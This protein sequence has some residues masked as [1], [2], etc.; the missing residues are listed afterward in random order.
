MEVSRRCEHGLSECN[1]LSCRTIWRLE[2]ELHAKTRELDSLQKEVASHE[3]L[4]P[5][6]YI[7][8]ITELEDALGKSDL[9]V[10]SLRTQLK[11]REHAFTLIEAPI[12]GLLEMA[13]KVD[14]SGGDSGLWRH[15]VKT[16]QDAATSVRE[17]MAFMDAAR[18]KVAINRKCGREREDGSPC[19][20]P[21]PCP[22][23]FREQK[24]ADYLETRDGASLLVKAV[25]SLKSCSKCGKV[26]H[27]GKCEDAE[28]RKCGLPIHIAGGPSYLCERGAGHRE[29]CGRSEKQ[30][31]DCPHPN[32]T[33]F[34]GPCRACG[35]E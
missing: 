10:E 17:S 30:V 32:P 20:G 7:N 18:A 3:C 26:W 19:P 27:R 8:R 14:R 25:D 24:M 21:V 12:P 5:I 34:V 2:G 23:H 22:S 33:G 6:R 11:D 13:E 31:A 28:K 15:S 1:V 4:P 35:D 9:Q 29:E 16:L